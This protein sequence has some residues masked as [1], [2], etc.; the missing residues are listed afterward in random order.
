MDTYEKK[1]EERCAVTNENKTNVLVSIKASVETRVL[2]HLARFILRKSLGAVTDADILAEIER[3]CGTILNPHV[4]DVMDAFKERL[5]MDLQEQDIEARISKYFVDFDRLVEEKGFL[6]TLGCGEEGQEP[7]RQKMKLR[8]RILVKNLAPAV[9]APFP[10][11]AE[12]NQR[13][14]SC[15]E[16]ADAINDH[17]GE[18]P[19]D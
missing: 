19:S 17:V 16:G 10:S 4:P 7:D 14:A 11:D 6:G 1:I 13:A 2:D 9:S 15:G 12:G 18:T 8:C 5:N 3:K